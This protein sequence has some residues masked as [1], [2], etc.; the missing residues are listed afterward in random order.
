MN[1]TL[2]FDQAWQAVLQ[3]DRD[4]D[5]SFVLAV[6]TT[7]IYCR[8]SC[9]ARKPKRENVSFFA[10]PHEAE[11]A[12]FRACLR[13]RPRDDVT[14]AEAL[15]SQA[16][17]LLD[18]AVE[19]APGLTDL[20]MALSVSPGHLQRTFKRLTG[21]SPRQYAEA[22]RL[23]RLKQGLR[24]GEGVAGATYDAGFGSSSRLYEKAGTLL[25]MTPGRYR[26]GG[27]GL[28]IAFAAAQ[29]S[30]GTLLVAATEKGICFVAVGDSA[31]DLENALRSEFPAA[32]LEPA[33]DN[34]TEMARSLAACIDAGSAAPELPLDVQ[35]T[36]FQILV[37][38]AL[39]RIPPGK[40]RSYREVA[41]SIGRPGAARAVARA[42]ATNPVPLIVPCHRVVAEDGSLAGYRW[43]VDRKQALLQRESAR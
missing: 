2:N 11:R 7:G 43:G 29:S 39:A 23:R 10:T 32:S 36:D 12:G 28:T 4:S 34:V 1:T 22:G 35:G 41:D 27:R 3:R 17:A 15:V 9:G 5:G 30:L 25:G 14:S 40:T 24:K 37:W 20:A 21:V 33:T 19:E 18:G 16:R 8:P 42:C 6:R 38:Q 31:N 13:C 26:R